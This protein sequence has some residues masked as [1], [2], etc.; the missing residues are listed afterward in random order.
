[1]GGSASGVAIGTP[2]V[3]GT[4][5][6]GGAGGTLHLSLTAGSTTDT[7]VGTVA[8]DI[9]VIITY[10]AA[11]GAS[12]QMGTCFITKL[13][14]DWDWD[15]FGTDIGLTLSGF[16][17]GGHIMLRC[18]VDASSVDAVDFDCIIELITL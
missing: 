10:G 7:S 9:G 15:Y 14:T 4:T 2:W 5:I 17:S 11:R 16:A 3:W 12:D 18:V 13:A 6:A 1:M 8:T